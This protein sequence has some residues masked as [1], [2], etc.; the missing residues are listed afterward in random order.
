MRFVSVFYGELD[1]RGGLLY[2]NAGH[3]SGLVIGRNSVMH[4]DPTGPI[5][6][7]LPD[8][9]LERGY[10]H[11][12]VGSILALY[13]DGITERVNPDGTPFEVEGLTALIQKYRDRSASEIVWQVFN[14]VL[15]LDHE[16]DMIEDDMTLVILKHTGEN[17]DS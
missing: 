7:P 13:T 5:M 9:P 12:P 11:I 10:V 17:A 16:S 6:G 2:G 4:L 1:R 14:H 15:E 3:T 8:M